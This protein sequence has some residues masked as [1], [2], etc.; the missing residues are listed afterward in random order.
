[1]VIDM[2]LIGRKVPY[3]EGLQQTE[4]GLCSVAMILRYY[5]SYESLQELREYLDVGRDGSSLR[6]LN[7]LLNTLN[8]NSKVYRA[9]KEGLYNIELPVIVYWENNHFIVLEKIT[10][11]HAYIV[12]PA[13]GRVKLRIEDF[14]ESYADYI[15]VA[16]PN[17]NFKPKEK[18]KSVWKDFSKIIFQNKVL[19][20]RIVITSIITYL[21]TLIIPI[22]IK[23]LIDKV[24]SND[25]GFAKN[26]FFLVFGITA[27][28]ACFYFLRNKDLIDLR[29]F[30]DK[31]M[32]ES[33]FTKILKVPY[34]FFDL[35]SKGD[36]LFTLNSSIIIREI[37]ANQVIKG[38]IDCGAIIFIVCYMG[39]QST[40]MMSVAM[41][42]FLLNIAVI[43]SS[44]MN[45]IEYNKYLIVQQSK[46][47]SVQIETVYS[48]LG[49]KMSAIE[50]DVFKEW[51]LRYDNYLKKYKY[52]EKLIN[53]VGV[54]NHFIET[55][56]PLIVLNIGIYLLTL[57]NLTVGQ[58][59][60][61][62]SLS[63]TFFSLA[64]SLAHTW[65]SFIESTAYLER[66][67]D[68]TS[69]DN[70]EFTDKHVKLELKGNI[71]LEKVS[72]SYSKNSKK[73]LDE[74]SL[75]IKAG[76]KVAIVGKSGSGKSTL[77]KIIV[78]LYS[79][80]DGSIY[81]DD[82]NSN[83]IN[84]KFARSQMGIV[85]QEVSLF[86]KSIYENISMN[87]TDIDEEAIIEASKIA[88]IHDEIE[89]M[90]M[91]YNTL[92]AEMGLNL[93]GGQR[94][95]IALARAILEKPKIIVLDEATSS[96]DNI[97]ERLVSDYF[98]GL[99]CTRVVLA[100]RLSTIIDAD[101]I[102]VLE[103]GKIVEKGS[104]EELIAI[105]GMYYSLYNN[106]NKAM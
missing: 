77:A 8:F 6:Q 48:I 96:L 78:G 83:E 27:L 93:S 52:K 82:I 54:I 40:V 53:R 80:I 41:L 94:Q 89:G 65:Y 69:F 84:R 86:N 44:R 97:N 11:S 46:Y 95:R 36:I 105:K 21:F 74:I 61:I 25:Y 88:Q 16:K 49:V 5:N 56:S 66:I 102:V 64:S 75:E 7:W 4:C 79:P 39:S 59:V 2:K 99:G 50:D 90:P 34:K 58:V 23:N 98:K 19:F 31:F 28:Y 32:S 63:S 1:M 60:A 91:K 51:H 24:S 33:L 101:L 26:S 100:H 76:Q 47:Q 87:R 67:S 15:I 14:E 10:E 42:L 103:E 37:F 106:D 45:I 92:V 22:F 13:M 104:H 73:V 18:T 35:R 9:K 57:G 43:M 30:I 12:D 71:K 55:I 62:Y 3:V 38:V 68:I 20:I 29:I 85:P 70:E 17:E 81:Y 72:F